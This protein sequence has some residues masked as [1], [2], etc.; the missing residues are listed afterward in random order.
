MFS[1]IKPFTVIR[2]TRMQQYYSIEKMNLLFSTISKH[3]LPSL[4]Q[5]IEL[6]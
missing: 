2:T 6:M 5:V 4:K 1:K 3:D